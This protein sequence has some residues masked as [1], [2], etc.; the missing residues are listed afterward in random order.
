M[1][2]EGIRFVF[3]RKRK[4]I[5]IKDR[6]NGT[7]DQVLDQEGNTLGGSVTFKESVV[8]RAVQILLNRLN[9]TP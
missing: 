6:L 1:N 9:L 3:N 4:T 2:K 5:T 7:F 8:D